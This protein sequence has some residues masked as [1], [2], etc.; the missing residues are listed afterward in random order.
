M[1]LN[2][3]RPDLGAAAMKGISRMDPIDMEKDLPGAGRPSTL[4]AQRV[5]GRNSL[6]RLALL[7]RTNCLSLFTSATDVGQSGRSCE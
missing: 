3:H 1:R 2:S 7:M 5:V 6:H 4:R